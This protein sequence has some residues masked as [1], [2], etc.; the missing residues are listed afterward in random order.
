MICL[1]LWSA[2]LSASLLIGLIRYIIYISTIYIYRGGGGYTTGRDAVFEY[3]LSRLR[4]RKQTKIIF[5][6][7]FFVCRSDQIRRV[8]SYLLRSHPYIHPYIPIVK[9]GGLEVLGWV[10]S[11]LGGEVRAWRLIPPGILWP[12]IY[13]WTRII[14]FGLKNCINFPKNSKT[15]KKGCIHP[16]IQAGRG[17]RRGWGKSSFRCCARYRVGTHFIL[18]GCRIPLVLELS[19][20]GVAPVSTFWPFWD[21]ICSHSMSF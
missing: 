17:R 11:L 3:R 10:Q 19:L 20:R 16:C 9:L 13:D 21:H 8:Q 4:Q 2:S 5:D 12:T 15:C 7:C 6:T 1:Y 14:A 18:G